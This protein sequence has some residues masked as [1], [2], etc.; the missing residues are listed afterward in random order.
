MAERF[1]L[2]LVFMLGS[3]LGY[4]E[5][6]VIVSVALV[7]M[8]LATPYFVRHPEART[9]SVVSAVSAI[10]ALLFAALAYAAGRGIG[11]LLLA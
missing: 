9:L 6:P 2:W 3:T 1:L 11:W 8:L 7:A 5:A 4:R 10:N